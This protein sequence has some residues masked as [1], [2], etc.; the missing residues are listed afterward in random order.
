MFVRQQTVRR[1]APYG[2]LR[3]GD[4]LQHCVSRF[5]KQN[6]PTK[7]MTANKVGIT[8][9]HY[10]LSSCSKHNLPVKMHRRDGRNSIAPRHYRLTTNSCAV[11]RRNS[12]SGG[13]SCEL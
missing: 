3:S 5:L 4:G 10:D 6:G 1:T 7:A 9:T 11:D 12:K 8:Y 13:E 2:F